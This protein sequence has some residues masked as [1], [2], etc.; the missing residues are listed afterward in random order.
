MAMKFKYKPR[1]V[2]A[3][4]K[5]ANQQ[6]SDWKGII[7]D[8]YKQYNPPKGDNYVRILPPTWE[9][10]EHYG[11]EVYVHFGIG[12]DR[13]SIICINHMQNKKCPICEARQ[14]AQRTGDEELA[15]E[16][17]ANKRVLVWMLDR[18]D[19]AKGPMI[20][21]MPWTL[22]RDFV[23]VSKDRATGEY[24]QIDDPENGYDISFDKTGEGIATKYMGTQVA[25]RPSSVDQDIIDF[26]AEEP[27]PNAIVYLSYDEIKS[28]Y[29]GG[30]SDDDADTDRPAAKPNGAAAS[31]NG[32]GAARAKIQPRGSAAKAKAPEPEPEP[33]E[34]DDEEVA[35]E[36]DEEAVAEEEAPVQPTRRATVK[37]SPKPEA[38]SVDPAVAAKA[39]ADE[40]RAR[41]KNR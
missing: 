32:N 29:E 20:W 38:A 35:E 39:R 28:I 12:P 40:L 1:P 9:D 16:L 24:Y 22:D 34:A 25:R 2:D 7:K 26:I 17:Q 8:D 13:A 10:P 6:G 33:E 14:R 19:E 5:R 3:W 41:F 27:L 21:S 31:A 18:K 11:L 23:K 37:P 4:E 36:E 15:R 30:T